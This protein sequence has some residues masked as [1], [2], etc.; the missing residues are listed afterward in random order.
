[1]LLATLIVL[2]V[3]AVCGFAVLAAL[4]GIGIG[5]LPI[6]IA[7]ALCVVAFKLVW[8]VARLVGGVLLALSFGVGAVVIAA[9]LLL[10][11]G[12]AL[13]PVLVVVGLVL[14]VVRAAAPR[15]VPERRPTVS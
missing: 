4:A 11:A 7:L 3:F 13:L 9:G 6:L 1:M 8:L 14:L 12:A 2:C 15:P 10:G 5:L